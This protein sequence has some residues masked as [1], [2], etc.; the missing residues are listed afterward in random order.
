VLYDKKLLV[1]DDSTLDLP[2]NLDLSLHLVPTVVCWIDFLV[3]NKDF[4]R[5]PIHI[6]AI[7]AFA[8]L[9]FV[10]VNICFNYN[11]YWPYPLL[12]L[13]NDMERGAFFIVCAWGCSA[14]YKIGKF[15]CS[16]SISVPF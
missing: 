11:G 2:L 9:Y 7:Y 8:M 12:I 15:S 5:S 13:F 16:I 1:P 3:F 10:W 6:L 14:I 4:K